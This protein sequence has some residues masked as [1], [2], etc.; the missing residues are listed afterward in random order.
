MNDTRYGIIRSDSMEL[1][2]FVIKKTK[3]MKT[4]E[5]LLGVPLEEFLKT[6]YEVYHLDTRQIAKKIFKLTAQRITHVSVARWLK[7]C[8]IKLRKQCWE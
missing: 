7:R 3:S 1:K 2:E 6:E 8:N 5:I 4:I